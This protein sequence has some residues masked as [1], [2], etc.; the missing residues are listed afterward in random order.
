MTL[1]G[2]VRHMLD[3]VTSAQS[4]D[5]SVLPLEF[6]SEYHPEQAAAILGAVD[7]EG[8]EAVLISEAE[9]ADLIAFMDALTSPSLSS[10]PMTDIPDRVPSGLPL[11]D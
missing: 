5:S 1:E 4:F 11:A 7:N 3:P 10:L 2:A 9:F 8:M 6:Q